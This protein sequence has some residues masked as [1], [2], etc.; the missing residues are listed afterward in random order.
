MSEK[1]NYEAVDKVTD[2]LAEELITETHNES[3]RCQ[4]VDD[5]GNNLTTVYK[6]PNDIKCKQCGKALTNEEFRQAVETVAKRY[7]ENLKKKQ[8]GEKQRYV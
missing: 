1:N 4:H 8:E 3:N 7:N 5:S 6:S 2:E